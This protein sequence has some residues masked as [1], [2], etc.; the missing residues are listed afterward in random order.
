MVAR[1][2]STSLV[3][4]VLTALLSVLLSGCASGPDIASGPQI[5]PGR[6][7]VVRYVQFTSSQVFSLQNASSGSK[8]EVYGDAQRDRSVKV[9]GDGELQAL[10][11]ILTEN[12]MLDKATATAAPDARESLVIEMPDRRWIWTRQG[13]GLEDVDFHNARG[14]FL[15][16]FNSAV[17]YHGNADEE[18]PDLEGQ[19]QRIRRDANAAREKLLRLG[20]QR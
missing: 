16:M 11:D 15:A 7:T 10:I 3:I 2:P 9:V 1:P 20:R 13:R 6:R 5:E 4:A 17:A 19:R 14:Y 12:G 8:A 18:V